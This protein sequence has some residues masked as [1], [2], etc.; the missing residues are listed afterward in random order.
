M[1]VTDLINTTIVELNDSTDNYLPILQLQNC[2]LRS[3]W[4]FMR[5]HWLMNR[6]KLAFVRL[7]RV[8]Q[9]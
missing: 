4:F 7:V 2:N 6:F 1:T 3:R 9:M 5:D 8:L